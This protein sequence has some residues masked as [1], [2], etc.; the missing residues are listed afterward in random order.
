MGNDGRD[1]EDAG[2]F[3][4][5]EDAVSA[6]EEPGMPEKLETSKLEKLEKLETSNFS[7]ELDSESE[8]PPPPVEVP[9]HWVIAQP[10]RRKS[11]STRMVKTAY[12]VICHC[13]CDVCGDNSK[14]VFVDITLKRS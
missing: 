12:H 7:T 13:D 2:M 9:R 14:D 10:P 1:S 8:E 5:E 6:F 11:V 4:G 3:S